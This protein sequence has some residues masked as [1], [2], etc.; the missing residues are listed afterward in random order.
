MR[1][2]YSEKN[3]YE[4]KLMTY[5]ELVNLYNKNE[6]IIPLWQRTLDE[7]KIDDI[8]KYAKLNSNFF[9]FQTNPIQIISLANDNGTYNFVVDGQHRLKAVIKNHDLCVNYMIMVAYTYCSTMKEVE[10]IYKMINIET[11]NMAIPYDEIS[12]DFKK[13]SYV[14]L[15]LLLH[16]QYREYFGSNKDKYRYSLDEFIN[17]LRENKFLEYL[18]YDE[19]EETLEYLRLE[20]NSF[21]DTYGYNKIISHSL[22]NFY[23]KEI[24]CIESK[25]IFTLKRNNFIEY[26]FTNNIKPKH[27]QKY[28]KTKISKILRDTVW[29]KDKG[30][31]KICTKLILDKENDYH[32]GHIQSEYNGGKTELNNLTVLCKKCNLELGANNIPS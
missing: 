9:I 2:I 29:K 20:N 23:E 6:I 12:K 24:F 32:C 25:I 4:L 13:T 11:P 28:V 7:T 3:K 31:C 5:H 15:R 8:A 26:L 30:I 18:E 10:D 16:Q 17:I 1:L 19:L 22:N 21:F 27:E 14:K